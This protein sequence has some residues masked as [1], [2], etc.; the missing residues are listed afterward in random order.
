MARPTSKLTILDHRLVTKDPIADG[1]HPGDILIA[2]QGPR[3]RVKYKLNALARTLGADHYR[4]LV[5]HNLTTDNMAGIRFRLPSVMKMTTAESIW[6][7]LRR[8]LRISHARGE[9]ETEK[10]HRLMDVEFKES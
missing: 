7:T 2:E 9:L 5:I 3:S 4:Q 10:Y 6:S 8:L 1:S